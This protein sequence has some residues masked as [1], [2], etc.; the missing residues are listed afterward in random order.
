MMNVKTQ[1]KY[2]GR[3]NQVNLKRAEAKR[4]PLQEVWGKWQPS[5]KMRVIGVDLKRFTRRFVINQINI[6]ENGVK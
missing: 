6:S 2:A 3:I 5:C 4:K 1:A